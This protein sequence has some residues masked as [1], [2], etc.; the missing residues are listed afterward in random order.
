[1]PTLDSARRPQQKAESN[2]D[3][4]T[5]V[6]NVA[7]RDTEDLPDEE[8]LGRVRSLVADYKSELLA[9]RVRRITFICGHKDGSYPGYFTYRGPEYEEDLTIRHNEPAL[10][11]QLEL[12][13]LSKFKI[14]PVFTE[15]RNIHIYEAIGK[16]EDRDK[17]VDKRYFVR[18]VVRPGRLKDEIP[19]A[20]YLISETDR[21]VNDICDALEVIGNNNSDLNHIFINFS[22]VFNLQ[23][24]DVEETIAGFLE[25]SARRFLRLRIT[26]AEVRI[27]CTDPETGMPYPL[28]VFITNTSGYVVNVE[29]YVERKSRTGDWVFETIGATNKVGA[30]HLRPV[31]TPYPTKEWLQPKRYKA[32]LMGTQY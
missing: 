28:R 26:G 5:N 1:M 8:I 24:K 21:L 31:S 16:G 2:D 27:L 23:P 13:R 32:H 12:G 18:A 10:A 25:R 11:F 30:M 29:S 15:N 4:L 3:D 14:K 17:V 7:I 20:E 22:P 6:C 19:T 9:R